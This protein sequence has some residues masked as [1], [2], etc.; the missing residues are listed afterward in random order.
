[1]ILIVSGTN[2]PGSR[3]RRVADVIDR[4][5]VGRAPSR[6]LDLLHVPIDAYSPLAYLEKPRAVHPFLTAAVDCVG[7]VIVT[8]EYNGSFPG[9][10]KHFIDLLPHPSPLERKPVCFVGLADGHWGALRAVEHLQQI[11]THRGAHLLPQRV[12]IPRVG[13]AFEGDDLKPEFLARLDQQAQD[14][15]AFTRSIAPAKPVPVAP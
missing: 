14:F 4:L 9:A 13:E 11:C 12:F 1:M 7:L 8:P 5:Y 3:T 15:L 6:I 10:L 2:R